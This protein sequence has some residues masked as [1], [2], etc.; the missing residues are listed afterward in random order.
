MTPG[1]P[2]APCAFGLF[3][4]LKSGARGLRL[5]ARSSHIFPPQTGHAGSSAV[6]AGTAMGI[7]PA[8]RGGHTTPSHPALLHLKSGALGFFFVTRLS[9]ISPPQVGH[10]GVLVSLAVLVVCWSSVIREF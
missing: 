6:P 5:L 8:S 1:H 3:R 7:A 10:G 9:H 4:H 2:G